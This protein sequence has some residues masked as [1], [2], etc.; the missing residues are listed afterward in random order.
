MGAG[1]ELIKLSCDD[2]VRKVLQHHPMHQPAQADDCFLELLS[3]L[4][5][6]EKSVVKSIEKADRPCGLERRTIC[7]VADAW[8]FLPSPLSAVP[9]WRF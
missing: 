9:L 5:E 7:R 6:A 4:A 1:E 2:M 3:R 8:P